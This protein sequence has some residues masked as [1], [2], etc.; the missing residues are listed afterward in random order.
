MTKV[1]L[2]YLKD[3]YPEGITYPTGITKE[4]KEIR[5]IYLRDTVPGEGMIKP[6]DMP[7]GDYLKLKNQLASPYPFI[8]IK[9]DDNERT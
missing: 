9:S 8:P 6:E 1:N 3:L 7:L 5:D 2:K 4:Q